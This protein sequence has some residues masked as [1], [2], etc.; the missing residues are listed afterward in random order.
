MARQA[1][2]A[3]GRR[4]GKADIAHSVFYVGTGEPFVDILP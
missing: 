2:F 1:T 4:G 3:V